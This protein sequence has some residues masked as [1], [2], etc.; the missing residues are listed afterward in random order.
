MRGRDE[1]A[2]NGWF[3]LLLYCTSTYHEME[4]FYFVRFFSET[5]G[6][7]RRLE[8]SITMRG[9]DEGTVIVRSCTYLGGGVFFLENIGLASSRKTSVFYFFRVF[10]SCFNGA[11]GI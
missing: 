4:A 7:P 6:W 5:R 1:G 9:G 2:V 11:I 8:N 10:A 3:V